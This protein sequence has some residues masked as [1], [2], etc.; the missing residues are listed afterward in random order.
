MS[1]E[2]TIFEDKALSNSQN[3]K[4]PSKAKADMKNVL[5]N[6][7][8]V[9]YGVDVHQVQSVLDLTHITKIPNAPDYIKGV[10]NLRGNVIP[11]VDLRKK[12]S[13][14][15]VAVE[16]ELKMM[17]VGQNDK[18]TGILVDSVMEVANLSQE[19]IDDIPDFVSTVESKH[20]IGVAKYKEELVILLD[21]TNI[22]SD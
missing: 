10:T 20:V 22:I 2:N 9:I 19:D 12:F 15:S 3:S 7:G 16:K 4:R 21:L 18:A 11:V 1:L 6:I 14:N 13:L 17:V 8:D 5:F